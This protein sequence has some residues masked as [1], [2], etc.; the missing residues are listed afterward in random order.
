MAREIIS[1]RTRSTFKVL[2]TES[3]LR[4]IKVAFED[5]GFS[6][7][8]DSTNEDSSQRRTLAQEYLNSVKWDDYSHCTRALKAMEHLLVPLSPDSRDDEVPSRW[9]SFARA[10]NEDG[11]S[12]SN[13]GEITSLAGQSLLTDLPLD[14]LNDASA[15]FEQIARLRRSEDDPAAVIGA[16]KELIESTAKVIL[17][18]LGSTF[19]PNAKFNNLVKQ[20]QVEL[21]LD[22]KNASGVDGEDSTK[23]ILGGASSIALGLNEL[24][25]AGH[26]TGHGPATARVGLHP[27]HARL[28]VNAATLWCE[29]VLETYSD[30]QAPWR[31]RR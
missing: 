2:I 30:P 27:R 28:A 26:G 22:P 25:N 15:I 20:V 6:P 8:P 14:S 5:E 17:N 10:L 23:R 16:A 12:I 9:K 7:V 18:E 13:T 3:T 21:G 11:W 29:F 19:E 4:E 24:R 31:T 1:P